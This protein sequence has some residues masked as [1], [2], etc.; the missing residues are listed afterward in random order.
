MPPALYNYKSEIKSLDRTI[1]EL[2]D[3]QKK[4]I[5]AQKYKIPVDKLPPNSLLEI[6]Y[7][8]R[9]YSRYNKI[10]ILKVCNKI[11]KYIEEQ[12]GYNTIEEQLN[13]PTK[14]LRQV[15]KQH[16]EDNLYNTIYKLKDYNTSKYY[17]YENGIV[18]LED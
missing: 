7:N 16:L 13:S 17:I 2:Q 18:K 14:T 15:K 1:K 9:Y 4:Y 10:I 12:Y 11:I 8:T 3:K 6:E 5:N